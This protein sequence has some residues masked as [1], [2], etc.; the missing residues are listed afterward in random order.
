[1]SDKQSPSTSFYYRATLV[2]RNL[3]ADNLNLCLTAKGLKAPIALTPEQS[4][5]H[6]GSLTLRL[7]GDIEVLVPS[8]AVHAEGETYTVDR[9][10]KRNNL[11][12]QLKPNAAFA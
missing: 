2:A 3:M 6:E 11:L 12:A 10:Y 4:A 5:E 1:M 9:F 8:D 7:G